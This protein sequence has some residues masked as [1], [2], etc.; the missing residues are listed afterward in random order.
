MFS[1]Y[2]QSHNDKQAREQVYIRNQNLAVA[3]CK[4]F[5]TIFEFYI[6]SCSNISK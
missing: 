4:Y 5:F 6:C 1:E 3:Y 2:L